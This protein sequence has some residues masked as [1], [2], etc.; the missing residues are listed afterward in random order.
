MI[1]GGQFWSCLVF[2][3]NGLLMRS[4]Y[5]LAGIMLLP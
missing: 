1:L 3:T 5:V 2:S 4:L